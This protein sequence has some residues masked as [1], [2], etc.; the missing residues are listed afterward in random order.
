MTSIEIDRAAGLS[1]ASAWKGPVK[2]STPSDIVLEG[3]QTIDGI[4]LVAG[5]RVLVRSQTNASENGIYV[6]DT[7]PWVRSKDFSRNDDVVQGTAVHAANRGS[8]P[9]DTFIVTN[10]DPIIIDTTLLTFDAAGVYGYV[11]TPTGFSLAG[12]GAGPYETGVT[13]ATKANLVVYVNGRAIKPS[14]ITLGTT[15]FTLNISPLPTAADSVWGHVL[16]T[17]TVNT[18]ADGSVTDNSLADDSKIGL[19]STNYPKVLPVYGITTSGDQTAKFATLE[20]Q[21]T[22]YT[23]DM[24]GQRIPV[25]AWQD[26]NR[27][28]NGEQEILQVGVPGNDTYRF[29]SFRVTNFNKYNKWAQDKAHIGPHGTI[30]VPFVSGTGHHS[31]DNQ[32]MMMRSVDNA[33][34]FG[35]PEVI[36][37]PETG[38]KTT[39]TGSSNDNV[40]CMSAGVTLG[41]R[42]VFFIYKY[43]GDGTVRSYNVWHRKLADYRKIRSSCN[44]R[45]YNG[46]NK[47]RIYLANHGYFVGDVVVFPVLVINGVDMV[48]G[49]TINNTT[50]TSNTVTITA[51]TDAYFEF[52]T[53]GNANADSGDL[54]TTC[55]LEDTDGDFTMVDTTS[56][57]DAAY[58]ALWP[59]VTLA[60]GSLRYQHSFALA[61]N[62]DILTTLGTSEGLHVVRYTSLFTLGSA[63]PTIYYLGFKGNEGTIINASGGRF[64]GFCRGTDINT[65]TDEDTN[66]DQRSKFWRTPDNFASIQ[67]DTVRPTDN[68]GGQ[69]WDEPTPLTLC[70]GRVL[71]ARCERTDDK[72]R[73]RPAQRASMLIYLLD[74]DVD[75]IFTSGFGAFDIS[76]M[77]RALWSGAKTAQSSPG[78]GVGSWVTITPPGDAINTAISG[79][80]PNLQRAIYFFGS[81]IENVTGYNSD[82]NFGQ[83]F[84][85]E[86]I[87][88]RAPQ[89]ALM[90]GGGATPMDGGYDIYEVAATA[91]QAGWTF[92]TGTYVTADPPN[93]PVDLTTSPDYRG[94]GIE[95][96]RE[97]SGRVFMYGRLNFDTD[98][99]GAS[100][101]A[102]Q[103][104]KGWRPAKDKT[105][106]V[107]AGAAKVGTRTAGLT[108]NVTILG[109]N[110]ALSTDRGL[111]YVDRVAASGPGADLNYVSFDGINF[112]ADGDWR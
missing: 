16:T 11:P 86:V 82:W 111:V 32:I 22:G 50:L 87:D 79:L 25:T 43:E 107:P 101:S 95:L 48:A 68:Y 5:D 110:N 105:F 60:S 30:F 40:T 1:S 42:Q 66:S 78:V 44:A 55:N 93:S 100:N 3:L 56:L 15:S 38:M 27:Y 59:S 54:V 26:G 96:H 28:V 108:V 12:A 83:I 61:D 74:A 8:Q 69:I 45:T 53:T 37:R 73:T 67:F 71:A 35:Y 88:K 112:P 103:L 31:A 90:E 92:S 9:Y 41:G 70:N 23:I 91:L 84:G 2:I 109:A 39:R 65:T 99:V 46:V 76:V 72:K 94:G 104:P 58:Q 106:A 19:L 6:V 13:I 89:Q 49:G 52:A 21:I 63:Q 4:S 77:G 57:V 75:E 36:L 33:T 18:P 24:G 80:T 34:S 7:G 98:A 29:R 85:I 10:P 20:A 102:F 51:A 64:C 62:G 17:R 97:R 14:D 47:L 81:E